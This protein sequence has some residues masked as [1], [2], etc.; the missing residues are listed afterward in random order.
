MSQA[1]E[2]ALEEV[3]ATSRDMTLWYSLAEFGLSLTRVQ[4]SDSEKDTDSSV[5][6]PGR[7][8]DDRATSGGFRVCRKSDARRNC[9]R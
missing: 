2:Q 3:A 5:Q 8:Q 6:R 7:K 4:E 9:P 1:G